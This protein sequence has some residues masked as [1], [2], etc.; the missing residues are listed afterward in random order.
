LDIFN[1]TPTIYESIKPGTHT[2]P[3][4][5]YPY[6]AL[7][8]VIGKKTLEIHHDKLHK[9]YVEALNQTELALAAAREKGNYDNIKCLEKDLAFNGSGHILHSIFWMNM[10]SPGNAKNPDSYVLSHINR[11]FGNFSAFKEQFLAA[12]KKVEASG[13]GILGY[14]PAFLCLEILQCEKHQNLTQWSVIPI[15]VCDVWE[16]A[17]F[18]DYHESRD[19]YVDAWWTLINWDDVKYRLINALGGK[20]VLSA[21]TT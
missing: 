11:S 12:T 7:E 6:N 8:P 4:L 13:W 10:M 15:L 20:V 21:K 17:Y 9:R 3:P 5:P 14:N 18:L 2:L 1:L 16:H 19:Q